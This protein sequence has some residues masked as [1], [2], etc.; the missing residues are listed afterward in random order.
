MC[1]ADFRAPVLARLLRF[2]F[3]VFLDAAHVRADADFPSTALKTATKYILVS[4]LETFAS[5][6]VHDIYDIICA[7]PESEPALLDLR[8]ALGPRL[9]S[10]TCWGEECRRFSSNTW[11]ELREQLERQIGN[12]LLLSGV[13]TK[14]ILLVYCRLVGAI[15]LLSGGGGGTGTGITSEPGG[16]GGG[17]IKTWKN[18]AGADLLYDLLQPIC[19]YLHR[20]QDTVRC[21]LAAML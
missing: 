7:L 9:S 19:A 5:R 4:L 11:A 1:S 21:V 10:N 15:R 18:G 6:R 14:Q 13:E 17:G 8:A 20:R 2:P 3:V 12:N 16:G